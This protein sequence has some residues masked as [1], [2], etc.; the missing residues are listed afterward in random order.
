MP[1]LDVAKERESSQHDVGKGWRCR[2]CGSSAPSGRRS[3]KKI[4]EW[5]RS[6]CVPPEVIAENLH[7]PLEVPVRG[8]RLPHPSHPLRFWDVG[9]GERV[10]ACAA[11]GCLGT[12]HY[13]GLALQCKTPTKA[14]RWNLSRLQRGLA[15]G[16]SRAAVAADQGR[17]RRQPR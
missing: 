14:G 5:L 9:R 17:G 8:G 13:G 3:Q 2:C 12:E 10:L 16:H 15:P 1:R 6:E 7:V 4:V 11:C